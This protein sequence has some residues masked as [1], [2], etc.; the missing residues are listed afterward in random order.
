MSGRE[1]TSS[2]VRGA[3]PELVQMAQRL[4]RGMTA[5]ER[6]LWEALRKR[7]VNGLRFRAQHA[8]G[9]FILD[10]CCP[11]IRLAIEVD[12]PDHTARAEQDKARDAH[13][14]T[15]GYTILRFTNQ[16]VMTDLDTVLARIRESAESAP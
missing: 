9:Q 8:L 1:R 4:R 2:R 5:P 10:F 15:Y 16:L 6:I 3:S 13:L 11:A 14:A 12:G 7:Q